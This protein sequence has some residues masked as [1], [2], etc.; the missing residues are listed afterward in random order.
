MGKH[1]NA[2]ARQAEGS[3]LLVKWVDAVGTEFTEQTNT[4][5]I[6]ETGI[7]FYLKTP[8]WLDTHLILKIGASALFGRLHTTTAK[9]VRV[10]TDASGQQLVAARFDE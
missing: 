8:I 9:V 10:Q 3:K 7:S 5:D 4:R 6:S 2:A 1:D